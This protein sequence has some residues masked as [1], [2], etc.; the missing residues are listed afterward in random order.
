MDRL[1]FERSNLVR[2][3]PEFGVRSKS[4]LR[5][6]S[7]EDLCVTFT[8]TG[9]LANSTSKLRSCVDEAETVFRLRSGTMDLGL[10]A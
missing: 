2:T 8:V 6:R 10:G 1:R 9:E 3:V 4:V 7:A 5:D